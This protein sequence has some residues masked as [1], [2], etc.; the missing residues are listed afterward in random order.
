MVI[1]RLREYELHRTAVYGVVRVCTAAPDA[2]VMSEDHRRR[3]TLKREPHSTK[4]VCAVPGNPRVVRGLCCAC[5]E[6]T[7]FVCVNTKVY[8]S[9]D[10][11]F[12]FF[13]LGLFRMCAT[14]L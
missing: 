2:P 9:G 6:V 13:F 7:L 10:V 12:Y 1:A 3:T 11:L 4:I 14:R 8:I 5:D